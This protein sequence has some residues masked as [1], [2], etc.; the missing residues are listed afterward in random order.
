MDVGELGVGVWPQA[1]AC[2]AR[3]CGRLSSR[4]RR[5]TPPTVIVSCRHPLPS[6]VAAADRRRRGIRSPTRRAGRGGREAAGWGL[7]IWGR[8][9]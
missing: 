6:S 1:A 7:G 3:G 5:G 8:T 4:L 9:R 2:A